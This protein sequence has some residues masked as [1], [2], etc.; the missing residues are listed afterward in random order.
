M[1]WKPLLAVCALGLVLGGADPRRAAAQNVGGGVAGDVRDP[2]GAPVPDAVVVL[3][4]TETS[5]SR[6]A[7]SDASGRFR[8]AALP[9]GDYLVEVEVP[10]FTRYVQRVR[11]T[12]G[13]TL[14]VPVSLHLAGRDE[15]IEVVASPL[16]RESAELGGIVDRNL[17]LGLP[18]N[19]RSYEQL[20]LLEPGVVATTSRETA[21]LYQHGLKININGGSSRSNAFLLD[22]T[23]IADL[24]NNGLGSV[25]G[26]F[27][28]IEA[29]R[30]FQVLTNAYD[31]SHGGVSGGVVSIITKSGSHDLHGSAF[32]TLRDGRFD[33][34][35]YFDTEKPDFWRHQT[36]FSLGGPVFRDRAVFFATGEWLRE[37]RGITQLTT[38]PSIVARNGQL[39]DPQRPGET[40]A[41]NPLVRPY[42]E[43]FPVPNG[44]DLGEG[45]AEHR[46]EATRPTS[47][48]F[49]QGRVD[50]ETGGGNSLFARLTL[51]SARKNEPAS[52]PDA[53]V[54]W[55]SASR[56]L[57]VEDAYAASGS[58]VNTLRFSYS[59]T[60][61][62]QTDVT[63]RAASDDLSIVPGRGMPHMRIGGM[64]AFGS[65]VSPHTRARQR[66]LSLA[67]DVS[68]A[69]GPH[70]IKAGALVEHLDALVDFQIFWAG[71][72]SFPGI[73]QFLQGRPT[74]LSLALP[75]S[76]SPR[77]LSST[78]FG[79]YAQDDLKLSSS[80]TLTA[81]LRWEF[82]TA[83][84][85]RA[86]R[87]VGLRDPVHDAVPVTG[88]LLRTEMANLAP[89]L[90][91]TWMPAGRTVL[92]TGA[93]I[94]YD[95]NT[96]PFVAQTVGGNPPYFNQVTVRNP[97]FPNPS[98]ASSQELSLGVPSYDWRTP[99]MLHYNVAVEQELPWHST[100]T[101][102]YA[103][104][105]GSH[106]V[107][108][109]DLNAPVP[110][111]LPDGTRVFVAG[112][113]RRNPAFGAISLRSTDG[114]S[115]YDALQ[116]K[117]ARRLHDSLQFQVSYTLARTTDD[118]QGTV[119]TESDG[120]VTQWMDPDRSET[121]HGPA[122]F[123]RRH[124]LTGSV[125]W[126]PGRLEEGPFLLRHL[127]SD[128]TVGGIVAL[129]SGNPF[130]VGIEGDYSRT[131]AR[132]SVHRPNLRPGV[133]VD[134][135]ILGGA[136]RYFDASAFELQAPGTFGSV[137]RNS[138]RGPGL[139]T[140][141]LAFS[142]GLISGWGGAGGGLDLRVDIFNALNRVNL[143]MPQRIV[144]AGV[145]QDE[146]PISSAGRITST[147]TGPREV[148][149]S[150]RASW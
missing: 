30:E 61:L 134:D 49:G 144:F 150:I 59:F 62:Q 1:K 133:D 101:I 18:V 114:H 135:I 96:L 17:V 22:G 148:Q 70:L 29:V 89:R 105:R 14:A 4:H 80:L 118:T 87:L 78:Q 117:L 31:A 124:N 25:A 111:V 126:R 100:F 11:I 56:F 40:I 26:T 90:G 39:A 140:V 10:G 120:S 146:A 19:G 141:D 110:D 106:V 137:G 83:P 37:S 3:V 46:F 127:V 2:S 97:Q 113:P 143:G 38:V 66:L 107:R 84:T 15:A 99:R 108:S 68:V 43:A 35:G 60:D 52:Y 121:D 82:A 92:R 116:L 36:G 131:L 51:D 5:V 58:F 98:L 102:A 23:S 138:L 136:E 20:A 149:L 147:A 21:V 71:R 53:G 145:R 93:G 27:L 77:E 45:L 75:G 16:Q 55:E 125:V 44:A 115:A 33:A 119:P 9:P 57:T 28:G 67:D 95:I 65:L 47:D 142:K 69:R 63:G 94:F 109:G 130:T 79:L 41:V 73:A 85:E 42:L 91:L 104:S 129:R 8:L 123:D 32:A 132:V 122:D 64:P 112:R 128:W 81:G 7:I 50:L 139:A 13:Q 74:V 54:E 48:S 86:G 12:A 72:Y 103:G 6:R 34:K 76:A 88:S 24:Y